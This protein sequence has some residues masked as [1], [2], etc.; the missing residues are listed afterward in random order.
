MRK[1]TQMKFWYLQKYYRNIATSDFNADPVV[2]VCITAY[3]ALYHL[4]FFKQL[5]YKGIQ[6][7]RVYTLSGGRAHY[8]KQFL[9]RIADPDSLIQIKIQGVA[10][11]ELRPWFPAQKL[12][13]VVCSITL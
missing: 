7:K 1:S 6:N 10:S 3:L 11:N 13:V 5:L 2:L 8:K 4:F 9:Y 12:L